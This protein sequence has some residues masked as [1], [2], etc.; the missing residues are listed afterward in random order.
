MFRVEFDVSDSERDQAIAELWEFGSAGIVETATGLRAFFDGDAP[1]PRLEEYLAG[2]GGHVEREPDLDWEAVARAQWQPVEVG[3]RWYLAPDWSDAATPEGRLRLDM[4]PGLAC[5]SGWHEATQLCLE[6]LEDVVV[7]GAAVLDVGVGAGL[8]TRAAALLGARIAAG[9]D[10]DFDAVPVARERLAGVSEARLFA[11]SAEAVRSGWASTV[12]A[13]I[14]AAAVVELA[15]EFRRVL[16]P[17]GTL[18]V[19]GFENFE[20]AAVQGALEAAGMA[21]RRVR[22]KRGWALVECGL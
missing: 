14:S 21:L 22:E 18:L 10:V 9:C 13:N 16:A 20:L 2:R 17:G 7:E 19:S 3:R 11:G 1:D 6:A 12:V 8:L 5:G 4:N 15:G